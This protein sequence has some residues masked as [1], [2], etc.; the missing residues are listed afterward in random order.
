MK[1]IA[2]AL[3]LA[4]AGL[5]I[6]WQPAEAMPAYQATGVTI[7]IVDSATGLPEAAGT[8]GEQVTMSV[9][10]DGTEDVAGIQFDIE[11]DSSV[12][13]V[14]GVAEGQLPAGHIFVV[15]PTKPGVVTIAVAGATAT[16]AS[17]LLVAA[18]TFDLIGSPGDTT[19]L[20]FTNVSASTASLLSIPVEPAHGRIS[21][22][23]PGQAVPTPMPTST[24]RSPTATPAPS[25][26]PTQTPASSLPPAGAEP[27]ETATPVPVA[28][29]PVPPMPASATEATPTLATPTPPPLAPTPTAGPPTP[30]PISSTAVPTPVA[31]VS[32]AT[33]APPAPATPLPTPAPS[34]P[35]A[36]QPAPATPQPTPAPPGPPATQPT[37]GAAAAPGVAVISAES[38]LTPSPVSPA[39]PPESVGGTGCSGPAVTGALTHGLSVDFLLFGVILAGIYGLSRKRN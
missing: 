3:F 39:S 15:N 23:S 28:T 17:S 19:T 10:A 32:T 35:P 34:A 2:A 18:I 25:P 1:R 8:T 12:V 30:A 21:I 20:S 22:I 7:S 27:G 14:D 13:T 11:Y 5:A 29:Q 24:P 31:A 4:G 9:T 16:D 38:T 36:T 37:P 6:L 33:P 26:S